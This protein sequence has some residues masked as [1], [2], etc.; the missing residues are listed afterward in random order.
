MP[1]AL[2]RALFH[3]AYS[4][5][6]PLLDFER[7][8]GKLDRLQRKLFKS[9]GRVGMDL[10]GCRMMLDLRNRLDLLC[11]I[12]RFERAQQ[13]FI[14][15]I[16]KEG[17]T[18]VDAGANIG[19]YTMLCSRLV[20]PSGSV[21]AFEP[22]PAAYDR[23]EEHVRMNGLAN[24]RTNRLALGNKETELELNVADDHG[25]SSFGVPA[26]GVAGR[27]RVRVPV[28]TLDAYCSEMG[29]TAVALA[30]ID[31]EGFELHVLRGA[32][33]MIQRGALH[34]MVIEYNRQAQVNNGFSP[35][36]LPCALREAGF[37]VQEIAEGG[38]RP[39]VLNGSVQY[40]E[41]YCLYQG[42]RVK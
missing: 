19:I 33:K 40:A 13:R 14:R 16:V 26:G 1:L 31:V 30:K 7:N 17:D 23:L 34:T 8:A 29:I 32:G 25:F 12:R 41:L 36:D 37:A 15:S 35:D 42:S 22:S 6:F 21:H 9:Y 3:L 24:V 11:W 2:Y 38:V 39:F 28:T 18:V 27:Y 4:N 20:G 5:K 10:E